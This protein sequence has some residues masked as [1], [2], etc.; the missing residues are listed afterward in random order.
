MAHRLPVAHLDTFLDTVAPTPQL[1]PQRA[2][3]HAPLGSCPA[4]MARRLGLKDRDVANP[5]LELAWGTNV[6]HE[7]EQPSQ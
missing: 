1:A 2:S 7:A 3:A 6:A 5:I 4:L